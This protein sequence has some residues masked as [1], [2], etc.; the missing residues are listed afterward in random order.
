V[1][2]LK[3]CDAKEVGEGKKKGGAGEPKRRI[4]LYSEATE[5]TRQRENKGFQS[6]VIYKADS[7]GGTER[8][9]KGDRDQ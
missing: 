5:R 3:S 8:Q 4:I 2:R 7:K 6:T 1:N 9:T